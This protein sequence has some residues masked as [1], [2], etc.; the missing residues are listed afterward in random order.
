MVF[1]NMIG[2]VLLFPKVKDE[3]H[4]YLHAIRKHGPGK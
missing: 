4:R 2:L 3:L 1:P